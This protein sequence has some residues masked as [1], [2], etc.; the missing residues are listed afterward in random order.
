VNTQSGNPPAINKLILFV[1]EACNLRCRYCY[2]VTLGKCGKA[3]MSQDTA[4]KIARQVFSR[5]RSCGFVQFFGGEPTLN[6]PA[7]RA[8]VDETSLMVSAGFLTRPPEFGIVTNGA[9]RHSRE[10]ISFCR[11]HEVGV[12]VSLDG[13]KDIQDDLRPKTRGT[14]SFEDATAMI[15]S[16]LGAQIPL[17]VES[18]YTSLHI[19]MKCSIVDL[20]EFVQ[21]LGVRKIIFHTAY[22]PAPPEL[23]PF[24]D[25]HFDR[26]RGY[27]VD[28]VD[29]WF[30]SLLDRSRPLIDIYF[31][32]L[33]LPLLHGTGPAVTG[34]GCPAGSRDLSVGPD[35]DV[36][37]CHLLY[38]HP[39]FH[40]GNLLSD[41]PLRQETGLPLD[42]SELAECAE[43]FARY[44]CQPCGALNLKWGDAW[45]PP[46]RECEL[47]RAVVLRIGEL[48]F[49]RLAIPQTPVTEVLRRVADPGVGS[50][51]P[52]RPVIAPSVTSG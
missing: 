26:L 14:G 13:F 23:C 18:V 46:Q 22:P 36:Y 15:E 25:A 48:A 47:R 24:D 1:T 51:F 19:D 4:R 49:D 52:S 35:G 44:W 34:G 8:F 9:S 11:E 12:T 40:L 38:G 39:Q 20:L 5:Y 6:M 2:V 28:A 33:L 43:C 42:T 50:R 3:M 10:L 41:D 17:A 45:V 31:K 7:M 30:E 16:L 29:W 27:H 21:S 32:D 37:S